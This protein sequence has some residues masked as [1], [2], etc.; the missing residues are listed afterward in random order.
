VVK[1]ARLALRSGF[2]KL[3][4]NS[5]EVAQKLRFVTG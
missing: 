2:R 1:A 5:A 3:L 4:T